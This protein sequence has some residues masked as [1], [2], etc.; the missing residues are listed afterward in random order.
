MKYSLLFLIISIFFIFSCENSSDPL[1]VNNDRTDIA[2]NDLPSCIPPEEPPSDV[3]VRTPGYWKNHPEAWPTKGIDAGDF[4]Y[5]KDIAIDLLNM[6]EKGDKSRTIFRALVATK[7]NLKNGSYGKCIT[8][9]VKA[10]DAWLVANPLGSKVKGS[11]PEWKEGELL[12]IE[13]DDY[14]NGLLCAPHCE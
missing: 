14:N 2:I 4:W 13:L 11:S 12:Y 1:L 8:G 7:L 5:S 3:C 10:A 9:I 6:P